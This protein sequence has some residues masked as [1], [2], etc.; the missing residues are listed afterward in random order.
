M[1]FPIVM[2]KVPFGKAAEKHSDHLARITGRGAS[3]SDQP[4]AFHALSRVG[5]YRLTGYML[6]FQTGHQPDP[7]KFKFGATFEQ[8]RWLYELDRKL[9]WLILDAIE[10]I[11]VAVRS[12]LCNKLAGLH[13]P[14][15][16][17]DPALFFPDDWLELEK[18]IADTL[19][20]DLG[21]QRRKVGARNGTH[22]FLDHYYN[23]YSMPA[24]PPCWMFME[25]ASFGV[26]ARLFGSLVAPSDRKAVVQEFQFLDRKPIDEVVLRNWLHGI[27]VLRN[28]CAHH[29]RIVNRVHPFPPIATTNKTA[30]HLFKGGSKLREF[31]VV[32]AVLTAAVNPKSDWLRRLYFLLDSSSGVNISEAI[33]LSSPWQQDPVWSLAW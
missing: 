13:G 7:H 18:R 29:S 33:G 32:L 27:S 11:E 5:Y 22:L 19:E 9:R 6:P 30:A 20:F 8:V 14:H 1:A 17:T 2:T 28:R 3:V 23:A 26:V 21:T 15:W 25:V 31:I 12:A 16:H 10:P 24:M 4:G